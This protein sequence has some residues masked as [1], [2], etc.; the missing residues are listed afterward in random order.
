M[1]DTNRENC[2]LKHQKGDS[3]NH[4]KDVSFQSKLKDINIM[5]LMVKP[6]GLTRI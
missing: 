2:I 6:G 4:M 1:E 5:L 3:H